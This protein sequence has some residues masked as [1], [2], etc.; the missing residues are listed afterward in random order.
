MPIGTEHINEEEKDGDE[1][2]EGETQRQVS[3]AQKLEFAGT[4]TGKRGKFFGVPSGCGA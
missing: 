2:S 3:N 1:I 4:T